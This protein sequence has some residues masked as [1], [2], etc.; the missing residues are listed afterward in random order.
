MI[1]RLS[2]ILRS[3]HTLDINDV[4]STKVHDM[5]VA[6]LEYYRDKQKVNDLQDINSIPLLPR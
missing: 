1:Q 6:S 4:K 5:I 2:N 3:I